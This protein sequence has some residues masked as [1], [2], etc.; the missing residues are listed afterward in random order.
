[1]A[2]FPTAFTAVHQAF[3]GRKGAVIW[4][5]KSP[6]YDDS[7]PVL[8]RLFPQAR[9]VIQWRDPVTTANAVARADR[10][11]CNPRDKETYRELT[12]L[13]QPVALHVVMLS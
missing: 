5:D 9:F 8:A 10:R 12:E 7:L 11:C 6:S 3:A 13:V 2:D 4:G 1:M